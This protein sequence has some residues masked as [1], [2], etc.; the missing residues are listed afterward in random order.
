MR[1]R[2]LLRN[3]VT[4]LVSRHHVVDLGSQLFVA[5]LQCFV[6]FC[7]G[8]AADVEF[9]V[10]NN[11]NAK[12]TQLNKG[13]TESKQ[14]GTYREAASRN[15]CSRSSILPRANS[16]SWSNR[17]PAVV[18]SK[19]FDLS[20]AFRASNNRT[21]SAVDSSSCFSRR[22]SLDWSAAWLVACKASSSTF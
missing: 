3:N 9:D 7:N 2:L 11:V 19:T 21:L 18:V 6:P 10:V 12:A 14:A 16:A 1:S 4:V 15:R 13:K 17:P 20:S 8:K 5:S 22:I